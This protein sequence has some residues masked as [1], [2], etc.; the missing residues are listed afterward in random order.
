MH[1][2][3]GRLV[4]VL[5]LGGLLALGQAAAASAASPSPAAASQPPSTSATITATPSVVAASVNPGSSTTATVTLHA[6][7]PLKVDITT[8][9]LGQSAEDGSFTFLA[10]DQDSSPHSARQAVAVSPSSFHMNAGENKQV[11]IAI[12]LPTGPADGEHFALVRINGLPDGPGGN[13]GVGVAL[14]VPVL[15]TLPGSP[16]TITGS[17]DQLAATGGIP[18]QAVTITGLVHNTGT[19]H[20]GQ[21]TNAIQQTATLRGANGGAI[22]TATTTLTGNSLIPGFARTFSVDL[23]P[24]DQLG[25]GTYTVDVAA[26]LK[27]GT[28]LDQGSTTLTIGGSG[29]GGAPPIAVPAPDQSSTMLIAALVGALAA[30]VVFGVVLGGRRV[31]RRTA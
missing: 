9:G 29:S 20:Y 23:Q 30:V 6:G 28:V 27:D 25:A 26:A 4:R 2:R 8:Q 16:Q 12:A 18:G 10:P 1:A 13:V 22:A 19:I 24:A 17:L 11:S 21:T 3:P 5:A 31:R 7:V 14:G 15:L